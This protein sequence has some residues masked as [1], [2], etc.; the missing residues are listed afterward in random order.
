MTP[1]EIREIVRI[2]LDE[3][4]KSKLIKDDYPYIL[5]VVEKKLNEFFSNRGDGNGISYVLRQLLDD[6]YI[7]II[8]LHYRDGKTLECIAETMRVDIR[9]ILRNKKR[10]IL[11]IYELMEV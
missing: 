10:L 4:T 6:K 2:T 3:L 1:E 9:T 8:F 7:D 11:R 5:T